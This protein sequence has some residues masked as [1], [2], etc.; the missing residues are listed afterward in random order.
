MHKHQEALLVA[1]R[2]NPNATIR[3]LAE[4]IGIDHTLASY[5]LNKLLAMHQIRRGNKW[6]IVGN[7]PEKKTKR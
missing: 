6:E 4:I 3:K 1:I 5:H 2:D 7:V